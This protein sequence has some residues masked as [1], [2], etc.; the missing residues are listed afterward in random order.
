MDTNKPIEQKSSPESE[1]R[2]RL[3]FPYLLKKEIG[4]GDVVKK[5]TSAVGIKPCGAC[6][7]R[8]ELLN[9]WMNFR[10]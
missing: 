4:L 6:Q 9:E 5:T 3:K 7:K 10:P 8:A 1:S 2:F